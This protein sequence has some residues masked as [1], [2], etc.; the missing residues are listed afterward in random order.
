MSYKVDFKNVE[1]V[2]LES[3]PVAPA[4]AGLRANEARYFWNKYKHEYVTEPASERP[5]LV[6][7][8]NGVLSERDLK[9]NL[10]HWK[11]LSLK[12]KGLSGP[13]FSM[14]AA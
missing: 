11:F 2:G 5:E 7:Y 4:L 6:A 14:K 10:N 12:L 9:S 3:S 1:Q 8:V 13:M